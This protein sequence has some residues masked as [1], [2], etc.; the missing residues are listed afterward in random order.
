LFV[1]ADNEDAAVAVASCRSA[2]MTLHIG[3]AFWLIE[4]PELP[5]ELAQQLGNPFG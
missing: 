4:L 1:S 3:G 2:S 5:I